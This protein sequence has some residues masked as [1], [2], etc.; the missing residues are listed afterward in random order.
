MGGHGETEYGGIPPHNKK[1]LPERRELHESRLTV[2][3]PPPWDAFPAWLPWVENATALLNDD[4]RDIKIKVKAW[5]K[6]LNQSTASKTR[7]ANKLGH[8]GDYITLQ[9]KADERGTHDRHRKEVRE[10]LKK[11]SLILNAEYERD[12][13]V[14]LERDCESLKYE[15]CQILQQRPADLVGLQDRLHHYAKEF[16]KR[17]IKDGRQVLAIASNP[18]T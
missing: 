9:K 6:M 16:Y 4:L 10:I 1:D 8:Q 12:E 18:K 2:L 15:V 7:R 14:R 17:D 5:N 3:S 11:T 13:C